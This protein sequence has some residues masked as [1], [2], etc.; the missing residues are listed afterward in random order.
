[1][2]PPPPPPKKKK[3]AAPEEKEEDYAPSLPLYEETW[4][5]PFEPA[6]QFTGA[7]KGFVFK[8][9]PLGV[10]YYGDDGGGKSRRAASAGTKASGSGAPSSA[11]PKRRPA[12]WQLVTEN[13]YIHR[14][15]KQLHEDDIM[16][17]ACAPLPPNSSAAA[18]ASSSSA[19]GS[20]AA[21]GCGEA[22]INRT[23]NL[24]CVSGHCPSCSR[25]D[26][27]CGNQRFA[28]KQ[29]TLLESKRAGPKGFGLFSK[30]DLV[31]GQFIIE[32]VGEVLEEEEYARRKNFYAE[33][34][35]VSF[36]IWVCFFFFVRSRQSFTSEETN[37]LFLSRLYLFLSP[38]TTRFRT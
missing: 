25:D 6:A 8:N 13:V 21:G 15:A 5:G 10:G 29:G 4:D 34:G 19:A 36:L 33:V 38:E 20:V 27:D 2:L 3:Q 24:E 37:S 11:P 35:Q 12:V 32:Y 1:M 14:H 30:V 18:A 26:E 31:K 7:K 9:G 28:R 17:C 16:L 23:L 22:C